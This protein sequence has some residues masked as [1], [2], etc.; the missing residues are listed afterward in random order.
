MSAYYHGAFERVTIFFILYGSHDRC[1]EEQWLHLFRVHFF[2][3]AGFLVMPSEMSR[4]PK[5]PASLSF[6][7]FPFSY[8]AL[9]GRCHCTYQF[10][11]FAI[12]LFLLFSRSQNLH[13][14]HVA[15]FFASIGSIEASFQFAYIFFILQRTGGGFFLIITFE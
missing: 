1:G 8:E 14:M 4:N 9:S 5:T 2:F 12:F 3:S 10:A 11:G 13:I 15:L 7:L 6:L